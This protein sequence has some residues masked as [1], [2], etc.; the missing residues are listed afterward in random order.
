VAPVCGGRGGPP[1][2]WGEA[3]IYIMK[4]TWYHHMAENQVTN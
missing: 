3:G 4:A 1:P 2:P